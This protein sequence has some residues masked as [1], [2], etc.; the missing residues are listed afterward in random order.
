MSQTPTPQPTCD[1]AVKVVTPITRDGGSE[2]RE[3]EENQAP[4]LENPFKTLDSDSQESET[5]QFRQI[6]SF[7]GPVQEPVKSGDRNFKVSPM[8]QIQNPGE[9]LEN[10]ETRTNPPPATAKRNS[11]KRISQGSKDDK[12]TDDQPKRRRL[13][14]VQNRTTS[15]GSSFNSKSTPKKITSSSY[16]ETTPIHSKAL[17][18]HDLH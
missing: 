10:D 6:G 5:P 18:V 9:S 3:T 4:Y 11:R 12:P 15:S 7:G 17:K 13:S 14:R 8:S 16:K 2:L 1:H